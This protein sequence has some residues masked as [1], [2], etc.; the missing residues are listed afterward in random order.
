MIFQKF[1]DFIYQL[2]SY[3]GKVNLIQ[4]TIKHMYITWISR[5]S[6]SF[7]TVHISKFSSQVFLFSLSIS[8]EAIR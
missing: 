3:S 8:I 2:E 7:N 1:K 6:K 4:K 5:R